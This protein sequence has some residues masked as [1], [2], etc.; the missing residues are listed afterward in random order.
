[1][2]RNTKSSKPVISGEF[3]TVLQVANEF[4]LS[5]KS[6]QRRIRRG[7]FCP[8]LRIGRKML[9]SRT[10][11]IEWFKGRSSPTGV[12]MEKRTRRRAA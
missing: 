4:H 9:W 12:A 3:L 8:F 6:I 5:V 11:L 7:E 2:S 1:M 10:Q